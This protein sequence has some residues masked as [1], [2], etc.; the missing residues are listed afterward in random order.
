LEPSILQHDLLDKN[1]PLALRIERAFGSH[2]DPIEAIQ[3]RVDA[4]FG[5][6]CILWE[7]DAQTF[8][9]RYVSPSAER[10]LGYPC[11][12]WL[13]EPTFWADTIVHP[14]HR[15]HA[16]AYCAVCTGRGADHDF[17]YLACAADGRTLR[18][19]DVV[20][21]VLGAR[22]LATHLRGLMFPIPPDPR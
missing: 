15:R 12:R 5:P 21:V 19:Y 10:L 9:F 7:G 20:R 1:R 6:D 3:Q 11:S 16:I 14:D 22:G 4:E 17:E 8:Q 18:L 13:E 2:D